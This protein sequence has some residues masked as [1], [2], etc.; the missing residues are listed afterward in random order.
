M[1]SFISI[2]LD[3][4]KS[5]KNL[6]DVQDKV[7]GT[8]SGKIKLV[9]PENFHITVKFLG[10]I[11][12]SQTTDIKRLME[13]YQKYPK[14]TLK[15]NEIGVFPHYGYIKVI[16]AGLE[17]D[18]DLKEIKN[19][20]ENDLSELGFERDN[21]DFKPH[22]TIGRVKKVWDKDSLVGLLKTIKN[23]KIGKMKIDKLKLKKSKLT[24]DGPIYET[25]E[26]IKFGEN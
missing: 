14:K 5:K 18:P 10:D 26:E 21:K 23:E 8:E 20:L 22:I 15:V 6:I 2:D 12:K 16:W 19:G 17:E 24:P 25:L 11:E 4:E 1:R 13:K 9:K 3:N 7:K